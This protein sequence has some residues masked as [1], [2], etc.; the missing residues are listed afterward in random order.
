MANSES[1]EEKLFAVLQGV[2]DFYGKDM[3]DF[4]GSVWLEA[5]RTF[6]PEQVSK[7]L[8]AHLM[9][10]EKGQ[11]MPKP[12]DVV[13]QLQGTQTDRALMAWGKAL[14]AMQRIGAYSDVC[15]D[16]GL[17]HV[18][19]ED[20]GGW[21][22][23]CRT[24]YEELPHTQRRFCDS[25]RAYSR[26]GDVEYPSRLIGE[27]SVANQRY[28]CWVKPALIGNVEKAQRVL[29]SGGPAKSLSLASISG[30][31]PVQNKQIDG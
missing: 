13:R 27:T 22:K 15:F 8:S 2:H 16:D 28:G 9:D 1:V 26:R 18:V 25:Y 12:A 6:S 10:P 19:I 4:A 29:E 3:T 21:V 30:F 17:I 23:L 24:N 11:Y 5:C 31:L 14:D 7:A 20:I